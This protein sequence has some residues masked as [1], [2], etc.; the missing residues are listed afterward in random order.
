[1]MSTDPAD[2]VKVNKPKT[3][4]PSVQFD[5]SELGGNITY[6]WGS[7]HLFDKNSDGDENHMVLASD[8]S[9]KDKI[10]TDKATLTFEFNDSYWKANADRQVPFYL[11]ITAH[12]EES[13][14]GKAYG[15][16]FKPNQSDDFKDLGSEIN[17]LE[18]K[19]APS[20][21][22]QTDQVVKGDAPVKKTRDFKASGNVK[23]DQV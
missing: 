9:G 22:E 23:G 5:I 13:M 3:K 10:T 15:G 6:V 19:D 1:M 14:I 4:D 12:S 18:S 20:N 16:W 21:E 2:K 8:S 7:L 17:P 11:L